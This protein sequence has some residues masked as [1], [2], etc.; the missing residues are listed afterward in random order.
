MTLSANDVTSGPY[1]GNGISTIFAYDFKIFDEDNLQ[2][3]EEDAQGVQ[4]TKV[5]NTDYSVN[6]VGLDAGGSITFGTAPASGTKVYIRSDLDIVQLT[7][8]TNQGS[9]NPETYETALDKAVRMVQQV[10]DAVDRALRFS[11]TYTG[12]IVPRLPEPQAFAHL[13]WDAGAQQIENGDTG[14][15]LASSD[16][17]VLDSIAALKALDVTITT[18]CFVTS[19]YGDFNGGGGLYQYDATETANDNGG[20]LIIPNSGSGRWKLVLEGQTLPSSKQFGCKADGVTD[21]KA[22]LQQLWSL[23]ESVWLSEGNHRVDMTAGTTFVPA[24]GCHIHGSHNKSKLQLDIG[25]VATRTLFDTAQNM[26]VE[27]VTINVGATTVGA[28]IIGFA[29]GDSNLSLLNVAINAGVSGDISVDH[30]FQVIKCDNS[31]TFGSLEVDSCTWND[32]TR[33]WLRENTST[34]TIRNI[35]VTNSFFERSEASGWALNAPNG[36]IAQVLFSNNV[37]TDP[38]I[39]TVQSD[40]YCIGPQASVVSITGN[41]FRGTGNECIHIEEAAHSLTVTANVIA[42]NC[43]SA[44]IRVLDN[45]IGGSDVSPSRAVI[46]NNII[47]RQD[48]DKAAGV[49]LELVNDASGFTPLEHASVNNN[50]IV[51]WLHGIVSGAEG[52]DFTPI[53]DNV[54]VNCAIGF[55]SKFGAPNFERNYFSGCTQLYE[56]ISGGG[57]VGRNTYH[58]YTTF[59]TGV[60]NT[61]LTLKNGVKIVHDRVTFTNSPTTTDFTFLPAGA[62]DRAVGM[63]AAHIYHSATNEDVHVEDIKHD[64]SASL[65]RSTEEIVQTG[66]GTSINFLIN[67][68]N[69]VT[70]VTNTSGGDLTNAFLEVE[71]QGYYTLAIA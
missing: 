40:S 34:A 68:G 43:A 16:V 22:A 31:G 49:G 11:D 60:S 1:M 54:I 17:P 41:V 5:L 48:N 8:L 52:A 33:Y 51:G 56:L 21:D 59:V 42:M 23:G 26:R 61:Q 18:K 67:S 24:A 45:N 2:V 13:R 50:V 29:W 19:Y 12:T 71:L 9:F 30:A 27:N 62:N 14:I 15:T 7:D 32:V 36:E 20:T 28:T 47:F 63:M 25:A 46:S 6:G 10:R 44:G 55:R 66:G 69:L 70:R 3:I 37:F 4:V 58:D 35:R 57:S 65:A 38:F 53:T 39:G 64:G